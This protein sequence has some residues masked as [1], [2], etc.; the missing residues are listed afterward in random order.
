MA[1]PIGLALIRAYAQGEDL[2]PAEM[3]TVRGTMYL[4][5]LYLRPQRQWEDFVWQG[6][7]HFIKE[8]WPE[9]EG[10]HEMLNGLFS[11]GAVKP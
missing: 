4:I 9:V 1:D 10:R 5:S 11:H 6:P 7:D 8:M 2:S 3:E